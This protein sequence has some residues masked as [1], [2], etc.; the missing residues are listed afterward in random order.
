MGLWPE[1]FA[2]FG[3]LL[4]VIAAFYVAPRCHRPNFSGTNGNEKAVFGDQSFSKLDQGPR[5]EVAG[6]SER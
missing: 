5:S 3:V 1:F 4:G 6:L 2:L